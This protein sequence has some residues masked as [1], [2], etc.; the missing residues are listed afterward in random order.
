MAPAIRRA[1]RRIPDCPRCPLG[2]FQT[3]QLADGD[4]LPPLRQHSREFVIRDIDLS[5]HS[6]PSRQHLAAASMGSRSQG[7]WWTTACSRYPALGA[8]SI[9]TV[10]LCIPGHVRTPSRR[11][12]HALGPRGDR[13][14]GLD[15]RAVHE[16]DPAVSC[17]MP[18]LAAAL[19]GT[20]T[21]RALGGRA[22]MGRTG[23][24]RR[25][26]RDPGRRGLR[27]ATGEP[28]PRQGGTCDGTA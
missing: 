21:P 1:G 19:T 27:R 15:R 2:R 10:S 4:E 14:E 7:P 13:G 26:V 22:K 23:R 8:R 18:A 6:P 28:G 12:A 5:G 16:R 3:T 25:M 17:A 20:R 9:A 11:G 24:L